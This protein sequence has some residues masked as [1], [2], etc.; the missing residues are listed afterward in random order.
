[1]KPALIFLS[2]WL[3]LILLTGLVYWPG[4]HGDFLFDDYPNIVINARVHLQTLD[5]ASI[6]K[7][8]NG[9]EAGDIGR[10]LSTLSFALDYYAA[11][12]APY[13]YKMT[14][15]AVHLLNATLV[16]L[17]IRRVL[18]LPAAGRWSRHAPWAIALL[19]AIHPLQVSTV[20]YVV[21]RM[22]MLAL[23]FI[24]LGLLAYL[25]A[26]TAAMSERRQWAWLVASGALAALG[27]LGKE[28]A[29]LFPCYTLALELTLLGFGGPPRTHRSLYWGYGLGLTTALLAYAIVLPTYLAPHAFDGRN[30]SVGERLLSQ[31]RVLPMYIGQIAMPLPR[32]MTFY[33]DNYPVSKG[34]LSPPT[35]LLGGALLACLAAAAVILRRR[36]PVFS[37]GIAWFFMAHLLTSNV[38]NLEL[39]FEH[40]NYFAVLG[41]LLA[42]ADLFRQLPLPQ[43]SH[44]KAVVVGLFIFAFGGM[45]MI[46]SAIWGDP[47]HIAMDLVDKNPGSPRAASDLATLYLG[48]SG[49]DANSPF[50]DFSKREFER[51]AA[52][53]NASGLPEQGLIIMA[54]STGQPVDPA[55]WD[56]LLS[57]LRKQPVSV[58]QNLAV[59]GLLRPLTEGMSI[60]RARLVQAGLILGQRGGL[61]PE[62]LSQLG[63]VA[64]NDL[65]DS[66]SANQLLTDAVRRTRGNKTYASQ[67]LSVLESEGNT[68]QAA[69]V[70]R[71]GAE[72]GYWPSP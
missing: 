38:F 42:A 25:H 30:F 20:L 54:A 49:G 15:L 36:L 56:S 24:L 31:L 27:L 12:K 41:I 46:R 45:A 6:W 48:M 70:R 60:D 9:Y 18:R 71:V 47:L 72:M 53:P 35:T 5:W 32:A 50:Y 68:E 69:V 62:A 21:Q 11:G 8:L 43:D 40:R 22:E 3:L 63:D 57:K 65:H 26:R 17:L 7:A 52:L 51:A 34:L 2:S 29:V 64:I 14:N 28:T 58:E 44:I 33:Y 1:M 13:L 61:P 66:A 10:P 55:W 16:L 23:T 4:L 59:I 19:W 67:I 37:L 39:V